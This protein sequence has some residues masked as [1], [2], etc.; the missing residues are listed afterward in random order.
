MECLNKILLLSVLVTFLVS[1]SEDHDPVIQLNAGDRIAFIGSNLCSRMI[2]YNHFETEIYSRFPDSM[3]YVRNMCDGG[4]RPGFRP[5]SG[6]ND[7]WAFPGAEKFY[8]E[9]AQKSNSVGH[10]ETEDEWLDRHDINIVLAFFG[11]AE[12]LDKQEANDLLKEE[13]AAFITHSLEQKYHPERPTQLVLI[14]PTSIEDVNTSTPALPDVNDLNSRLKAISTLQESIAAEMN[15]PYINLFDVSKKWFSGGSDLTTDGLQLNDDGYKKLSKYLADVILGGSSSSASSDLIAAVEDKNWHWHMDYKMPNGVHAFGRRYDPFGPDNYPDEF[16]KLRELT[17]NRDTLVWQAAKGLAY[18]L[19]KADRKTTEL[20]EVESNFKPGAYGR[21]AS[22]YLYGEDALNSLTLPEGY[23]VNLFASEEDF[24]DLANPVQLSFDNNG[25]LWVACMPTYP[26]WK[27][28]DPRPDDKLIILEDTDNDGKADSQKV[29]A[30]G[31]HIPVGF[32]FAPEGV[33][34]SQGTNLVLMTDTDGDDKADKTEVIYS[35]FDDHD[36]H[37]VISAFCADPSGAL[38]MG[39]GVFL[40]TNVET[41]YGMVRG[42]NG[43]FYRFQP[44]RKHLER[45]AQ[46]SIPNPWGIAFDDWGQPIFA[47]TSGPAVRWMLPGT[48]KSRYGVATHKSKDLIPE[49]NKVRPT[50]GLEFVSSR[51]F[52]DEVQGDLILANSIGFLGMRQHKINDEGAGYSTD[53]RHDIIKGDDPNFRP[54]D[55]EFAPDGSLYFVDWHNVLIGHMQHNARDPYRDHVHGRIYRI[56]YP[57]RPLVDAPKVAGASIDELLENLKLPEYRARYRTRRELRGRESGKVIS[58]LETWVDDLDTDSENYERYLM[59]AMWVYWGLNE[60]ND[61]LL[62]KLMNA[63]DYRARAAAVRFVRYNGHLLDDQV[64][65]LNAAAED[66][67]DRVRLEAITAASWLDKE[68]AM[69][70]LSTAGKYPL[71]DW[72]VHAHQTAVAHVNGVSLEPVKK[73]DKM[74][75]TDLTKAQMVLYEKGEEIYLQDGYC[76][77]CHQEN[78]KGLAATGYPPL[79]GARWVLGNPERLVKLTLKGLYGPIR[80]KSVDYPGNVPMTPYEGLLDDE[81]IASVLTYVRNSFGNKASA[82]KPEFVAKVRRDVKDKKGFYDPKD[83][84]AEHPFE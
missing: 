15:V 19:E 6:R 47:E 5:H 31:L 12:A 16:K 84:L 21:G 81:E 28:G 41:P 36:T 61:S 29:W 33:Y 58:A 22:E 82:I 34:V 17:A 48:V 51:H 9:L 32:E 11:T 50:S 63:K 3:L 59:E 13:Y 38:Y 69:Q 66:D 56:T 49:E 72:L 8:D 2:N 26:H 4:N 30:D 68:S 23:Q 43:G 77:T 83:L 39:E 79:V 37:H 78:G 42:T 73:E 70:I 75:P 64:T 10:L 60:N 52:P 35:G 71:D 40:H 76:G 55:M 7:P 14:S 62:E 24:P 46:L 1:C 25:R 74:A 67:H 54:V 44:Q 57:A 53:L 80:V 20:K 27:P 65:L 45:T 18:D